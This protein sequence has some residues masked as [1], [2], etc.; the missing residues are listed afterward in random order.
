MDPLENNPPEVIL[1]GFKIYSSGAGPR[2][3]SC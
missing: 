3:R 1:A 2:A